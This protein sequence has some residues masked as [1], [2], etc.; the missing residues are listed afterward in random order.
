M[1][2]ICGIV[3]LDNQAAVDAGQLQAMCDSLIH[4]GPDDEGKFLQ[5]CVGLGS[6]RL[7]VI[8]LSSQGHMPMSSEDQRYWIT[9]NGEIYNFLDLRQDLISR[10]VYLRSKTDTEVLL[11]LYLIYGPD[12]LSRLNGMFAFAIWDCREKTLFAAR[13]RCGVKPFF[14]TFHNGSFFFASEEKAF[15]AAGIPAVFNPETWSELLYFRYTAGERTPYA[16]IK[17]LLP[18]YA[19]LLQNGALTFSRWWRLKPS[20][21]AGDQGDRQVFAAFND[22]FQDAVRS[23][24]ISDVPLGGLLSGGIDSSGMVAAMAAEMGSGLDTFTMRFD[25]PGYDE[26]PLAREVA[27]RHHANP[28]EFFARDEQIPGLLEDATRL[29]DEPVVHGNDIF[30][31]LISRYAKDRVTVLL[32]GEGADEIFGG[33]VRYRLF[34]YSRLFDFL[35]PGLSAVN[36]IG[37]INGRLHKAACTIAFR[38]L[39]EQILFSSAELFPSDCPT[40]LPV[41]DFTYRQEV[42]RESA[43]LYQEPIRQVMHY[44]QNTYLQSVLDRNDRMTMGASIECREPYLDYRLVEWAARL[45]SKFLFQG[46]VGKVILREGLRDRLPSSVLNHRK[47][48]FGIPLA[49]YMRAIP[50][51]RRYLQSLHTNEVFASCPVPPPQVNRLVAQFLAGDD[52]C[53]SFCRQFLVTALWYDICIRHNPTPLT[54]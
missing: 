26:G 2:G 42:I 45:P 32:S 39:P 16:G 19:L 51:L 9:Y 10:G 21:P 7:A 15:F 3:N 6:R 5:G 46:G 27:A 30:I 35:R 8:D 24:L 14:Y 20:Q 50:T 31:L 33:Y 13:D 17:R 47:W 11:Q 28:H 12:M 4:R 1:C 53:F 40:P 36:Q 44:E 22:Q 43:Q 48:G 38:S 25:E 54:D 52:R 49:R 34:H 37:A 29:L 23:R 41:P 18:G